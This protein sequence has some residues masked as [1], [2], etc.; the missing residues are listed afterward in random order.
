MLPPVAGAAAEDANV[1]T[2]A[3]TE[4]SPA[5]ESTEPVVGNADIGDVK[6]HRNPLDN[7]IDDEHSDKT[8]LNLSIPSTADEAANPADVEPDDAKQ[9]TEEYRA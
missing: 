4:I 5:S 9:D 3:D 8:T 7:L 2:S 6:Q 1:E